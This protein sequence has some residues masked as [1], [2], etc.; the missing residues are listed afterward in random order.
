[1]IFSYFL[2]PHTFDVFVKGLQNIFILLMSAIKEISYE[3][4]K[5]LLGKSQNLLL[6]DI[7]T[8]E[9]VDQ[10]HIPGSIHIPREPAFPPEIHCIWRGKDGLHSAQFSF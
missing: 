4:L 7:R 6:I 8:Q 10:G 1:M 3:D 9:E 2:L 5:A